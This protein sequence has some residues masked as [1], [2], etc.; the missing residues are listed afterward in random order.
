MLTVE[1][2]KTYPLGAPHKPW[3]SQEA[4]ELYGV[5]YSVHEESG[6]LDAVYY[7]YKKR[8]EVVRYKARTL[9]KKFWATGENTPSLFG[10]DLIGSSGKFLVVTEGEDDALAAC[11]MFLACGKKYRVV[12]LNEGANAENDDGTVTLKSLLLKRIPLLAKFEKVVLAFDNDEAGKP[13]AAALAEKLAPLT[14]VHILEFPEGIKDADDMCKAG[15][16]RDF[17]QCVNNSRE[18]IP[19]GVIQGK[20]ITVP[21]LQKI[22]VQGLSLPYPGLQDRLHGLR[23]GEITLMCAGS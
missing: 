14:S 1:E 23:P 15:R 4:A 9:P 19:E 12:S 10:E 16:A 17:M 13:Y 3:L 22:L 2:I 6:A 21:S 7:S 20:D 18:Y 5:R 8:G 11:S